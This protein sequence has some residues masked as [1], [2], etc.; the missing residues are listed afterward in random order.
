MKSKE[1]RAKRAKLAQEARDLV[2]AVPE[3]KAMD[4]E[5]T[6]KFDAIMAEV[7]QLKG[8]IDRVE[9]LEATEEHLGQR[10]DNRA[11]ENNISLD[12][13]AEQ[14]RTQNRA[15]TNYMRMGYAELN[16]EERKALTASR[17]DPKILNSMGVSTGI[18]GGFTVPDGFYGTLVDAQKAYGGMLNIGATVIDSSSGNPLPIPTDN[19]TGNVGQIVGENTT[20]SDGADVGFAAIVLGAY[21]YSSKPVKASLQ[22]LQDSAFDL[23][24]WLSNKLAIRIA[25]IVNTHLTVGDGVGK[26]TG[27]LTSATLGKTGAG[28]Q[29]TSIIYDDLVD[30]EHSVDP[31]Y[32]RNAQFMFADQTLKALKKIKDTQGRPLWLPGLAVKEPDTILSLPYT[33]NQD[34]PAPAANA[35]SM[36]FG[37]FSNYYIRR[38]AGATMVR[39]TERYADVGQVGFLLFQRWD[40]QLADAGTHPVAYF[41][42]PAS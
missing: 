15:F 11:R 26:P 16:D 14:L 28:G 39:L 10:I 31:A 42:H 38:V 19:D 3:G 37:D 20:M 13:A 8:Q 24:T 33:I 29:T 2:N 36:A 21:M 5:T 30:L 25:R 34:M 22:L 4:A 12:E 40:G 1:L 6:V 9:G 7:D 41:Q 23:D 35:K 17:V 32:R 18:G 27:V